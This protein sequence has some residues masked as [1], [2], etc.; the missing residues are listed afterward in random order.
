M[1]KIIEKKSIS[2]NIQQFKLMWKSFKATFF[3][4]NIWWLIWEF[5]NEFFFW[6]IDTTRSF[7]FNFILIFDFMNIISLIVLGFIMF[8]YQEKKIEKNVYIFSFFYGKKNLHCYQC[9][10]IGAES[11]WNLNKQM[12][13]KKIIIFIIAC[14]LK[15]RRK[16]KQ[17]FLFLSPSL[18]C[19]SLI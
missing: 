2:K 18:L 4:L 15:V 6:T 7:H 17:F 8:I 16:L 19:L 14:F 10:I 12:K 3:Q 13:K 1:A 5:L 11:E 9:I